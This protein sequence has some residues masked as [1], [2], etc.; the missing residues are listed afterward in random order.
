[1]CREEAAL[2]ALLPTVLLRGSCAHPDLRAITLKLDDLYGASVSA[3]VRRIGDIQTTGFFSALGAGLLI[4]V[5]GQ[6]LLEDL[7]YLLGSTETTFY[8]IAV[9]FSAAGIRKTR[10]TVPA[11]LTADLAGFVFAALSVRLL[12]E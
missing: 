3:L 5:V 7:A 4:C 12:M 11:A 1:M 2:N 10:Y 9:Y 8:T 6:S